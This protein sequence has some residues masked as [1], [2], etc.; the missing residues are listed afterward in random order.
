MNRSFLEGLTD[1]IAF[2]D[3]T[4]RV[5]AAN[6]GWSREG[7]VSVG[8]SYVEA[9]RTL[10]SEGDASAALARDGVL[11][12][13]RKTRDNFVMQ[14]EG[15]VRRYSMTVTPVSYMHGAVVFHRNIVRAGPS[16]A[17]ASLLD[18]MLP[19][20]MRNIAQGLGV[21]RA[22][23]AEVTNAETG[24]VRL[25]G[26][27]AGADFD[28][29]FEYPTVG[30]PCESVLAGRNGIFP[31]GVQAAFPD[32]VWLQ[33]IN[34][35][36]YMAIPI[37][38][39]EDV[40]VGHLG[41]IDTKPLRD[42][43]FA[44][45]VLRVHAA[46]LT[47]EIE[48]LHRIRMR[49][50]GEEARRNQAILS[51]IPDMMFTLDG[52]GRYLSFTPAEG[53]QPYVPPEAFLGR[54]LG[55]VLPADVARMAMRAIRTTLE[56]HVPQTYDFTLLEG[57]ELKAY[58]GRTAAIGPNEVLIIVRDQTAKA[59]Q[60]HESQRR[61]D[62][63][64]LE[65]RVEI[66]MN[67]GNPYGL[68]FREFVVLELVASGLAD[69]EIADKLGSKTFTVNKHVSNIL[70]KMAAMSRTEAAVRAHRE[71]LLGQTDRAA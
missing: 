28:E 57:T 70:T 21:N 40:A 2:I 39:H 37:Y 24:H 69:K 14:Y 53:L 50:R 19:A 52:H 61:Q 32:D 16:H 26:H 58:E 51:A 10:A 18:L 42:I 62:V 33:Q 22:F 36:G 64:V 30:T 55:E 20:L 54:T 60:K 25:L 23:V 27:W 44:E 56:T 15:P 31:S 38:D 1:E 65:S 59:F 13:L 45:A 11:G 9:Y 3:A 66:Q 8:E 41:I 7:F 4:G 12:V 48:R 29:L 67:Q 43:A 71:G 35:E 17:T 5:L 68:T 49:G 47:P 46:K 63:D 6:N 34:A